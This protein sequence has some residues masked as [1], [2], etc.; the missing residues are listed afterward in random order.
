MTQPVLAENAAAGK[1]RDSGFDSEVVRLGNLSVPGMPTQV[2]VSIGFNA[3]REFM[4]VTGSGR[5]LRAADFRNAALDAYNQKKEAPSSF[6]E[7]AQQDETFTAER[8]EVRGQVTP[9]EET[10][11]FT[12]NFYGRAIHF[13]MDVSGMSELEREN[14]RGNIANLVRADDT[15]TTDYTYS[16]FLDT[17]K[18]R[19]KNMSM[20]FRDEATLTERVW[21][22]IPL[23]GTGSEIVAEMR[24]L[25]SRA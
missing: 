7:E 25:T 1:L 5:E 17:F 23:E 21:G 18:E 22:A 8:M 11:S 6:R 14:L 20:E 10:A 13:E 24:K 4:V 9:R 19:I 2:N 3:D 15:H 12:A 16:S